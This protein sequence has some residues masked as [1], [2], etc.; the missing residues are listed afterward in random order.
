MAFGLYSLTA[1]RT[2]QSSEVRCL[3]ARVS[4]FIFEKLCRV[5]FVWVV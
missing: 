3:R 1:V 2:L 5:S 4:N